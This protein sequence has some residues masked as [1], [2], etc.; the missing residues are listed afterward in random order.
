MNSAQ[1]PAE[2]FESWW[3]STGQFCRAGGGDYEK[4]FAYAAWMAASEDALLTKKETALDTLVER[5]A[6]LN[7]WPVNDAIARSKE[8]LSLV[9]D[10][11]DKP[12]SQTRTKL[13]IR[14]HEQFLSLLKADVGGATKGLIQEV[15]KE[16]KE[17]SKKASAQNTSLGLEA[18]EI[19]SA[20]QSALDALNFEF[21]MRLGT[22]PSKSKDRKK[23]QEFLHRLAA[24]FYINAQVAEGE[25]ISNVI[26]WIE[27]EKI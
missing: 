22:R 12:N 18:C 1:T 6:D 9:D 15:L 13:R 5:R 27:A 19:N 26:A 20:L 24:N 8:I 17:F 23:L 21:T 14:L 25:A 11:H 10:Y 16:A 7:E 2:R 3:T 4:T